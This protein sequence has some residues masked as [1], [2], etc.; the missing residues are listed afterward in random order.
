MQKVSRRSVTTALAATALTGLLPKGAHAQEALRVLVTRTPSLLFYADKLKANGYN[1]PVNVDSMLLDKIFEV[2][3][4]SFSSN[5]PGIDVIHLNDP[6]IQLFASKGW[7][8]PLDDLWTKYKAEYNLSDFPQVIMDAVTHKGRIYAMPVMMNTQMLF[9]RKDIFDEIGQKVPG[10]MQEYLQVPKIL[11]EKKQ[12]NIAAG[13]KPVDYAINRIHWF[14][15]TLGDGWF[16]KDWRPTFNTPNSVQAIQAIKDLVPYA[17]RGWTS[18]A[19]DEDTINL[20]QGVSSLGLQWT[21]RA[22]SMNDKEKSRVVGKIA[23]AVPPGGGARFALDGFAIPKSSA[24]N[25]E[26]VFRMLAEAMSA[27]NMKANADR[28]YPARLSVIADPELAE[29][30][31]WYPAARASIAANKRTPDLPEFNEVAEIVVR[32]IMQAL[33]GEA[34]VKPSLDQA[35]VEVTALLTSKGYYKG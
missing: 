19:N 17:P 27:A 34:D 7:L 16:D 28:A 6:G 20:S 22:A 11:A 10:T 4:I 14:L 18:H 24:A 5:A 8:E 33:T 1:V 21:T 29:K 30:Y 25:K 3:S 35:A 9:Y 12:P 23:W 26:Q 15:N 13:M 31:P 2:S 32:R